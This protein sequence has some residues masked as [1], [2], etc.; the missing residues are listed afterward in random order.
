M[1]I[2][3]I[4]TVYSYVYSCVQLV[5]T[6]HPAHGPRAASARR[7]L[8]AAAPLLGRAVL[9]IRRRTMIMIIIMIPLLLSL[10]L[11]ILI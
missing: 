6:G 2:Y 3:L 4:Y 11:L 5:D 1:Y 9:L 10:L 8:D 7:G